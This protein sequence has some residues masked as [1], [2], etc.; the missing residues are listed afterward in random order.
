MC[1][2]HFAIGGRMELPIRHGGAFAA[3]LLDK[4][5]GG[6]DFFV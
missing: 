2:T 5:H 1:S 3:D 6:S 4:A